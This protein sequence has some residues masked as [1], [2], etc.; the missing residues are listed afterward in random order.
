MKR[1]LETF[2]LAFVMIA[3]LTALLACGQQDVVKT[4]SAKGSVLRGQPIPLGLD[5][6]RD[7]NAIWVIMPVTV[8][9]AKGS[10]SEFWGLFACY[11]GPGD[12]WPNV[13]QPNCKLAKMEGTAAELNWPGLPTL[14]GGQ[15][16]AP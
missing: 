5:R 1:H 14:D 8:T 6:E 4:S 7:A 12:E 16:K 10:A 11:R 9:D 15:L 2:G 3:G 13:P